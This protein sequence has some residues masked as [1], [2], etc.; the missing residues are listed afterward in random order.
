MIKISGVLVNLLVQL[1]YETY[2]PYVVYERG[3]KVYM[4]KSCKHY[5]AC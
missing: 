4:W 1:V 5:M 3:R 2:S